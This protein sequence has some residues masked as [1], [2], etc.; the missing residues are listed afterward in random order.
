MLLL[1]P[2]TK[3]WK[4]LFTRISLDLKSWCAIIFLPYW[5][6]AQK[7]VLVEQ[8]TKICHLPAAQGTSFRQEGD[9]VFVSYYSDL[10]KSRMQG[11]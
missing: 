3:L 9:D 6:C 10:H 5:L 1:E 2:H 4:T 7:I 8:H 11:V